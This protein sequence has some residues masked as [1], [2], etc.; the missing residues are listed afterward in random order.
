MT[1]E[2]INKL[3]ENTK[4]YV[5]GK[6]KEIQEKLFSL[7]YEWCGGSTKVSHTEAP[8]L[9]IYNTHYM[10]HGQDMCIFTEHEHREVS[11]EEILSLELTSNYRPFK[12]KEECWQE[13]IKHQ[14]FG[15]IKY[16]EKQCYCNWICVDSNGIDGAS[17]NTAYKTYT[18]AD[19]TPFGI[20]EK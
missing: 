2:E 3:L 9:Y 14:P 7:G 8:F 15:A 12:S 13:M 1:R 10:S 18:F 4:V 20:K 17:F 19:G 5:N 16:K 6:S 11:A